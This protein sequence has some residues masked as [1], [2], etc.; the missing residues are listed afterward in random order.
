ME[1]RQGNI[2]G[3]F[4]EYTRSEVIYFYFS[5]FVVYEKVYIILPCIAQ[6]SLTSSDPGS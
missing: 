4:N 3:F 2:F 6:A 5:Y 1:S